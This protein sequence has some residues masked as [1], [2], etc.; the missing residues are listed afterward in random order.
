MS[1]NST[2]E[3][4][5]EMPTDRRMQQLR[6]KG[7]L[8]ISPE[9]GQVVGLTAGFFAISV[10]WGWFYQDF[11]IVFKTTFEMISNPE[12][13]TAVT[14]MDGARSVLALL[15][16][17]LFAVAFTAAL[18]GSLATLVQTNFNVKKKYIDL[19]WQYLNPINGI[20]RIFSANGLVVLGKSLL[21][22]AIII[23]LAYFTL[24][25]FAPEMVKLIHMN[26][27][28]VLSL[29]GTGMSTVFWKIVTI[30]IIF[31]AV[32]YAWTKFQWLKQYKMTKE[33]VKDERKS[34][35][36]DEETKRKIINKGLA[37]IVQRIKQNVP[38]ADV[39]IT[40][41]THYAIALKYDRFRMG[42]PTVVAKGA[43]YLALRIR[44]IAKEAKVPIVERK[45]LARALYDSTEVG[46]EIPYELFRAVAEVLAYIYKLKGNNPTL[47]QANAR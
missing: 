9:V 43:D 46:S 16:P 39:V 18:F 33:E 31:A 34:V 28:Q 27:D 32:D 14:I 25:Q 4:R 40:N 10:V 5:T 44:E 21:K 15:A 1:E 29:T 41:P 23:P 3:Q 24:K 12:P 13:L 20:K 6:D 26:V 22:L 47:K 2:P 8:H 35:E 17:A 7:Q 42:A 11:Q 30:M 38:K 37:R 36:G 45:A 19:Q